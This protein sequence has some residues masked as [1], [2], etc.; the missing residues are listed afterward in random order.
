MSERTRIE[1]RNV[2][3]HHDPIYSAFWNDDSGRSRMHSQTNS[4]TTYPKQQCAGGDA[5][6]PER[7]CKGGLT[8][9]DT[10]PGQGDVRVNLCQIKGLVWSCR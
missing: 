3:T 4:G 7:L 2:G 9:Q 8:R 6:T 5:N 1:V 10:K